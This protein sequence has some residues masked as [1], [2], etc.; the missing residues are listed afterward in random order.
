MPPTWSLHNGDAMDWLRSLPA[1]HADTVCTDPPYGI[2]LNPMLNNGASRA[3]PKFMRIVNDDAPFVWWLRE[4]WRV[5]KP[6]GCLVCFAG[7]QTSDVFRQAI[8]WAGWR[9]RSMVVWDKE[10]PGVGDF[11]RD[12]APQHE[13]IWFAIKGKFRFQRPTEGREHAR[14]VIRCKSPRGKERTHPTEKPVDLLRHLVRITTPPGGLVI[15]PFGGTG[16]TGVASALEGRRF[17]GSELSGAYCQTARA[18]LKAATRPT[19][20]P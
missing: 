18:R 7:W 12:F 11:S 6:D 14:S 8:K 15:D 10:R 1:D 5:T 9:I 4:A 3:D 2:S 16:S 13:L 17:A 20:P 19:S